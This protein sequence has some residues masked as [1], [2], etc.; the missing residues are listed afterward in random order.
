MSLKNILQEK[1]PA[2]VKQWFEALVGTYPEGTR[3]SLRKQDAQFANPVGY[4][5]AEGVEAL[6]E[7]L[8]GGMLPDRVSSFLDSMIRIRAVQNF[9]PTQAVGFIFQLKSIMRAA[10]GPELLQDRKFSEDLV[11]LESA[12][13]DLALFAFDL[14]M[15]CREGIY[16]IKAK[17]SERATFRLLQQA[18]IITERSE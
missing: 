1:K 13:D 5:Y 16:D 10:L 15:H 7:A 11:A 3:G 18:K 4:H 12:V 2:I 8:L 9:T 17:E 14:Y 6:F